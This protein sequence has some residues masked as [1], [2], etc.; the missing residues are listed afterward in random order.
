MFESEELLPIITLLQARQIKSSR[1]LVMILLSYVSLVKFDDDT[2]A[3]CKSTPSR[4]Q[5]ITMLPFLRE[6]RHFGG[7]LKKINKILNHLAVSL[8]NTYRHASSIYVFNFLVRYNIS[9]IDD[10]HFYSHKVP[11]F[12]CPTL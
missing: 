11:T 9:T 2:T 4:A 5:F 1:N 6:Y 7:F 12:F 3:I 8:K 10:V